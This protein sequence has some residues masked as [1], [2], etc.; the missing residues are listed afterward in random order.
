[1]VFFSFFD[2]IFHFA[3][4]G[5]KRALDITVALFGFLKKKKIHSG[6]RWKSELCK[7]IKLLQYFK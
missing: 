7:Y 5:R 4:G 6:L 2:R 3:A 1:M